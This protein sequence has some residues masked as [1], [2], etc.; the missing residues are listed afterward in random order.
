[1]IDCGNWDVSASWIVPSD[2]TSGIYFAKAV[3]TDTGGASH[4]VFI[5][6]DD[7]GGS[8]MLFQTADT[9]WHAY[10]TYGGNSLYVGQRCPRRGLQGQLQ[11]TF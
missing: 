11:S 10:N 2:A 6:R 3:R 1:M 8:D 4:I 7:A 5:V 9:T